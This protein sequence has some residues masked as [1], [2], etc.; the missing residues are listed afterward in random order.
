M[1]EIIT[2]WR[3]RN[4]LKNFHPLLLFFYFAAV[5]LFAM[6][7]SNPVIQLEAL[8][9]AG[10][11]LLITE[12]ARQNFRTAVFYLIVIAAVGVSN[13]I[14][15]HNGATPL[16]FMNGNAV[17]LEAL[18]YGF[19]GGIMLAGV[20]LWCKSLT[21]LMTGDKVIYLFGRVIPSLSLILS[22]ALRFV[23]LFKRQ[24]K[25]ISMTQKAMGMY[26]GNGIT[27]KIA[28]GLSVFSAMVSRSLENAVVTGMSMKA[29]GYGLKGRTSFSLFK[30]R[31]QDIAVGA[32]LAALCVVVIVVAANGSLDFSFYPRIREIPTD[33][34]AAAGY[35]SFGAIALL[36]F[37]IQVKEN[38]KWR[39]LI[40]KI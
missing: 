16:F 20:M 33:T 10:L 28:G 3:R 21:H 36:P 34:G 25:Q 27:D 29:R 4:K 19:C 31:A 38:I 40:S 22:M 2:T 8:I 12:T 17:T 32:V 24:I 14:F 13:P 15:V 5:L 35:V 26:S 23:P 18:A 39:F 6:F 30:A 7:I 37:L 9:G 11:F 1:W